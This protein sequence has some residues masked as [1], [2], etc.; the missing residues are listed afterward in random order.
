MLHQELPAAPAGAEG[1]PVAGGHT[2]GHQP[3][4]TTRHEGRD[5][6][7]LR[8]K[9]KAKGRVLNVAGREQVAVLAPPGGTDPQPR[10]GR[11]GPGRYRIGRLAKRKPIQRWPVELWHAADTTNGHS[12]AAPSPLSTLLMP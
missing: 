4:A 6:P 10:I 8:A 2:D 7:A 11:I 5:E 12:P 9:G 3:A 1:P